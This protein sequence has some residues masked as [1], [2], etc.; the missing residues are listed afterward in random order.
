M[1][2]FIL[3]MGLNLLGFLEIPTPNI[4]KQMPQNKNHNLIIYPLL[5]GGVFAF[6]SSPCSTPI[7]AGIMAYSSF[8]ANINTGALLLFL[9]ALGQGSILVIA[10]LFTSAFKKIFKY[11]HYSEYFLKFSGAVLILGA[12]LIYTKI[13]LG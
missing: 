11:R 4:V 9:F 6:A 8:K 2:S 5:I 10:A 1:A 13:F 7:L 12:L 3:V